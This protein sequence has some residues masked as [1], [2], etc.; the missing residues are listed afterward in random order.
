MAFDESKYREGYSIGVGGV[1]L[2]NGKV[3]LVRRVLGEGKGEWAIPGGF[4]EQ[5]ETI[6]D[7][8]IREV[9]E[10][11]GIKTQLKGLIAVRNRLYKNENSAYFIFLLEASSEK[12]IPDKFEVDKVK[13]FTLSELEELSDLQTLSKIV[14]TKVLQGKTK[15]LTYTSQSEFPEEKYSIFD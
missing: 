5:K 13:F 7:A 1:V 8:I 6:D 10:E 14:A 9:S 12:I 2:R 11:A 4:V 3:L 15:L